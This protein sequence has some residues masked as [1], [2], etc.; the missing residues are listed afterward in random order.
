MAN[1]NG[2]KNVFENKYTR[3]LSVVFVLQAALFYGS[4]RSEAVPAV[5]PLRGFSLV[6][7][8]GWMMTEEGYVDEE[9]QAVLRADDTLTRTYGNAKY[10]A[11][12]NL[13]VAYFKTQRTGKTPHSPKNCLPGSGWEA[14]TEDYLD[15]AIP[16]MAEPIHVNRYIVAKGEQKSVVLYWYQT[17]RRVIANEYRAK[18]MTVED[19]IRYNRTDTALVRVVV[20]F[21]GS[22][23]EAQQEAVDFVRS[24]FNPL[25]R[26]LPA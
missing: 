4:S 24:F 26:Y 14:S 23:A 15:V 3:I 9:T 6:I 5:R 2:A 17:Q 13:F 20:P 7:P 25:R 8:G 12:A 21:V 18:V 10:R 1:D 19:A 22:D 11:P 16:G